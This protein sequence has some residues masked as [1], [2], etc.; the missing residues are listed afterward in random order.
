MT[1]LP[2][3]GTDVHLVLINRTPSPDSKPT[4][5]LNATVIDTFDWEK[6][7]DV[8]CVLVPS[9]EVI[10]RVIHMG[11]VVSINGVMVEGWNV[12]P[13]TAKTWKVESNST[14]NEF[15]TVAFDGRYWM[16]TCRGYG[17]HRTCSHIKSI[18]Q[19]ESTTERKE[20]Q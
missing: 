13:Q 2:K 4:Y 18:Q 9:A 16:C 10:E 15:Y 8:F 20:G 14:R 19:Q 12:P 7:R 3:P 17:F 5:V 6:D 1:P 11:N